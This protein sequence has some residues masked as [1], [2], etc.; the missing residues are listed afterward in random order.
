[1]YGVGFVVEEVAL[2]LDHREFGGAGGDGGDG[3]VGG[4]P[5]VPLC[6]DDLDTWLTARL[7]SL[8]GQVMSSSKV[9][10]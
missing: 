3:G 2:L 10:R 6:I 8:T 7:G 4:A 5:S 1:M 9:G